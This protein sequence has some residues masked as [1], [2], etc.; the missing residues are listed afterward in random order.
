ME[1][2]FL[3]TCVLLAPLLMRRVFLLAGVPARCPG[4]AAWCQSLHHSLHC[5]LCK[6]HLRSVAS[7]SRPFQH[8][9]PVG[10]FVGSFSCRKG[11]AVRHVGVDIDVVRT[12]WVAQAPAL[13]LRT[14]IGRIVSGEMDIAC[15]RTCISGRSPM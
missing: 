14:T 8:H 13:I 10:T 7:Y 6:L 2:W 3:C 15:M 12:Y 4:W 1:R 9:M 11:V 5:L